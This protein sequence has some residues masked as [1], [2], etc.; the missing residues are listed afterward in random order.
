MNN[1]KTI[2][3][4]LKPIAGLI[5]ILPSAAALLALV[6]VWYGAVRRRAVAPTER[7]AC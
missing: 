5:L 7:H 3:D 1:E 6:F 2:H 4:I